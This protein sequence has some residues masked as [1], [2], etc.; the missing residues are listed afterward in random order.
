MDVISEY[1]SQQITPD[2][3]MYIAVAKTGECYTFAVIFY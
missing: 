3:A 2:D 1:G